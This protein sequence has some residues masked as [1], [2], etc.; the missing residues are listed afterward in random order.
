[1]RKSNRISAAIFS[2]TMLATVM[3]APAYAQD[4]QAEEETYENEP[5]IVTATLRAA[6]VQ[7]IPIAVTAVQPETLE[8]QGI[9][10][11]KSLSSVT[12]SFNIQ[13][14]QNRT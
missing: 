6:D 12:P 11:I 3:V 4:A 2:T 7:D 8:R 9:A 14:S 1:M 10:D 5:I 13:S